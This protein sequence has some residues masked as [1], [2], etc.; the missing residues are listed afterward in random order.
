[1]A[2]ATYT[3]Q[4]TLVAERDLKKI[5]DETTRRRIAKAIDSLHTNPRPEGAVA[6]QG[7]RA[8][9]RLRVGDYRILYTVKDKALLVLVIRI[10][11]RREIY[12]R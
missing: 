12:R 5:K 7:D 6:L 9:L 10:G 1:V 4:L 2:G 11:N 3:V 8:I